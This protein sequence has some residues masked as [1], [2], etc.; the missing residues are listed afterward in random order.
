[1]FGMQFSAEEVVRHAIEQRL[2]VIYGDRETVE[3]GGLISYATNLSEDIRRAADLLARVLRGE[4]PGDLAIDQASRF[5][6][7]INLGTARSMGLKIPQSLLVRAD[8]V[9]E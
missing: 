7:A 6:L 5:E 8:R 9:I 3:G 1:M 4:R 2:P